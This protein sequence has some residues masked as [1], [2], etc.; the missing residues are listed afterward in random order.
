MAIWLKTVAA[1]GLRYTVV[2]ASDARGLLYGGFALL[3]KIAL[4]DTAVANLDEH[5]SP[6]APIRWVNQWDNLDGTIERGY[7]GRSIFWDNCTR[8]TI[9]RA[10]RDY[11]PPAGVARHQRLLHQQR[12]RQPARARAPISFRRSRASPTPF[13]PGACA[14]RCRWISAARRPS[15]ASTRSIRSTRKWPHGGS[16]QSRRASTAPFPISAA[17]C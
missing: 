17:S 15:A 7:G 9:S 16:R 6:Y 12:Q 10:S 14:W 5:Q 13:V 8:A 1:G 4:G 2:A 11:A 3:R